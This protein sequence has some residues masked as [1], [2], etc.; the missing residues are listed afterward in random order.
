[1]ETRSKY[2]ISQI[3]LDDDEAYEEELKS[4]N[5][6]K[7]EGVKYDKTKPDYSLLPPTAL[8]D[9][10][11]VLTFGAEKY[12]RW[13]WKKLDNLEDRYFAAAQR[14][15]WAVMRGETHDPESGEHHYAHALC[16]IMYLL[17]FYS[18]QNPKNSI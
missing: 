1:M 15:L 17:E 2:A 6:N 18:L 12:D 9:V 13:N 14:H 16:C 11:K 5:E 4:Y 10:V 7:K 3:E 8:E